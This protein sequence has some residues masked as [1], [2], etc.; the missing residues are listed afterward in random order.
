MN[1]YTIDHMS[2]TSTSSSRVNWAGMKTFMGGALLMIQLSAGQ[3]PLYDQ[4]TISD[5][6][7]HP[8]AHAI[9]ISKTFGQ[10]DN[11]FSGQFEKA[12]LNFE[13]QVA[14]FYK[15]LLAMQE[16]LGEEFGKV[17]YENLSDLLVHT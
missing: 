8:S 11:L 1:N 14:L 13:E 6:I 3:S 15:D 9:E 2:S 16:P 17:L 7:R 12:A 4:A 10:H 5:E